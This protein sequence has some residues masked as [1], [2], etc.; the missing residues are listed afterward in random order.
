VQAM[1]DQVTIVTAGNMTES[2]VYLPDGRVGT[3]KGVAHAEFW[4]LV[5]YSL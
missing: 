5:N 1:W 2:R 3:G 4:R